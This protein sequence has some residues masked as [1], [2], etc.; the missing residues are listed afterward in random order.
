MTQQQTSQRKPR[1]DQDKSVSKFV[2]YLKLVI[3]LASQFNLE[4]NVLAPV[5]INRAPGMGCRVIIWFY[6]VLPTSA[7]QRP[8]HAIVHRLRLSITF[9]EVFPP[10]SLFP[11]LV[12]AMVQIVVHSSYI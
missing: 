4:N 6:L 7:A 2:H 8:L 3:Q 10:I 9:V 5:Y 1:R 11:L 12:R